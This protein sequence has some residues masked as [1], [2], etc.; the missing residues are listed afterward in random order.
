[1]VSAAAGGFNTFE[2]NHVAMLEKGPTKCSPFTVPMLIAD[3]AS[4]RISMKYGYK[5][6][7]KAVTLFDK[8]SS[9]DQKKAQIR[10]RE[11]YEMDKY[12]EIAAAREELRQDAKEQKLEIK[13]AAPAERKPDTFEES[14]MGLTKQAKEDLEVQSEEELKEAE[15]NVEANQEAPEAEQMSDVEQ[16]NKELVSEEGQINSS[17]TSSEELADN[18]DE[19]KVSENDT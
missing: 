11:K 19:N 18:N 13:D 17:E 5:G 15:N 10:A 14:L 9:P 4:G 7:N 16:E 1:M 8:L 3:M 12:S 6:I 2:K